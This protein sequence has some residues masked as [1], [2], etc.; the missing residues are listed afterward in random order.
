M[1]N[2]CRL[3]LPWVLTSILVS[4]CGCPTTNS[5]GDDGGQTRD[6]FV[7]PSDD[8]RLW[9]AGSSPLDAVVLRD[10][11]LHDAFASDAPRTESCEA[12]RAQAQ[13]C[14]G[15]LCDGPG[16]FAWD[17]ERCVYID[18]GAC[19]G[20]D[21]DRVYPS[22]GECERAHHPC[23]PEL[24]RS[25]GGDWRFWASDCDHYRCG[26]PSP[27]LCI[28]GMPVCDCGARSVFDPIRGCVEDLS[29]CP[30]PLP[31][32]PEMLCANT[33]GTWAGTCCPSTCGAPCAAACAA[34]ACTC[35]PLEVWDPLRG[36]VE[37]SRCHDDRLA[38]DPCTTTGS[39]RCDDGLLCCQRCGGDGCHG[40]PTC[41]APT[42]DD[43]G[44]LDTCGNDRLAP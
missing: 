17:G 38:G 30:P 3:A 18:C 27:A 29:A 20:E 28:V 44:R 37:S 6:A 21:C 43:T 36:C 35:G 10:A 39:I 32:G 41:R 40:E 5:P 9:D 19:V 31:P 12:M 7:P 22:R 24:C 16:S 2:S 33:G 8:A 11:P 1:T 23:V 14:P 25:T 15:A 26:Q 4:V 42:C 13:V 34:M